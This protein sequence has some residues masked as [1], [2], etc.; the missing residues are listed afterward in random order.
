M[1]ILSDK[2]NANE[3][4]KKRKAKQREKKRLS[5][6]PEQAHIRKEKDATRKYV[7]S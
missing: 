5:E 2:V 1:N 6:T 3:K 4:D 7:E